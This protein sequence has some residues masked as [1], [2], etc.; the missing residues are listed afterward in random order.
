MQL[1]LPPS[2][3]ETDQLADFLK[4]AKKKR[5]PYQFN[6]T[7]NTGSGIYIRSL[8]EC[9]QYLSLGVQIP[10][11]DLKMQILKTTTDEEGNAFNWS[12][13]LGDL[14]SIQFSK[15]Y[16][17]NAFV[18]VNHHGYWFYIDEVDLE[19]KQTFSMIQYLFLHQVL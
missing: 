19:S 9:L 12:Q 11:E 1:S 18:A 6:L 5:T 2:T 10:P 14:I 7:H 8:L 15:S 4:I 17:K 3:E 16:P 13:V